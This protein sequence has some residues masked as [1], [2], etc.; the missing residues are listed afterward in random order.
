LHDLGKFDIRFQLKAQEAF[1]ML[2]PDFDFSAVNTRDSDDYYH[3]PAGYAWFAKDYA[4]LFGKPQSRNGPHFE[5]WK[6]WLAAVTGHHGVVPR[7]G[8][9]ST[10][11]GRFA[12]EAV[13][14]N[15][16]TARL[17]WFKELER[18]FLAPAGLSLQDSPLPVSPLLAGFCSVCDWL[19]SNAES[20]FF[21]Y[22]DK[23]D[24]IQGYWESRL[25]IA[26][27]ALAMAGL[28]QAPLHTGGFATLYEFKARQAQT[29]IDKLPITPNLT[30][31]EA[32]T[33]SGKTEAR[34]SL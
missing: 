33:G 15:D 28:V 10:I 7:D 9:G 5:R 21:E 18:L 30:L 20:G 19:G 25:S 11:D 6:E 31:I 22:E 32:P 16:R 8:Q 23:H 3:G 29:L 26:E 1:K 14:A 4:T 17:E 27:K 12:T 34:S 24:D 13:K 2:R